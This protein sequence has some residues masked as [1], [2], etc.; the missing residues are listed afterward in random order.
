MSYQYEYAGFWIRLV[1]AI[2]DSILFGV[3]MIPIILLFAPDDYY[4][5]MNARSYS[6]FDVIM[7]VF[8]AAIYIACWIKFAGTP[9]KRLLNL[10]ILDA[11]TGKN[12]DAVQ[13]VLRYVGYF[14][15]TIVI[16]LGFIWIVF[17]PKKQGWHDKM[18]KTVVVRELK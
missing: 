15:S 6:S 5:M 14:V 13:G 7:Q 2:I 8:F 4:S 12:I 11:E 3:I 9:G 18:A 10:K 16:F 1:A 17:D